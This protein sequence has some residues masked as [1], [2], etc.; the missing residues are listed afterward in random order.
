MNDHGRPDALAFDSVHKAFGRT[1][2]LAG[3]DLTVSAG[4]FL[5]LMGRN[6]AGKTTILRL[7]AGLSRP[8]RGRV[9]V[10]GFPTAGADPQWRSAIGFLSHET[11]LYADLTV[12]ENLM[13]TA[14][15]FGLDQPKSRVESAATWLDTERMLDR[16][17]RALSRGMRQRVGLTRVFLSEPRIVLLDEPYTGLDEASA[18]MLTDLLLRQQ[19][20]GRTI[21]AALHDVSQ[22]GPGPSRV[23]VLENG[24]IGRD[25]DVRRD[26]EVGRDTDVELARLP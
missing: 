8:D 13:F 18:H 14:R 15:L 25:T 2:V 6:G 9:L 5:A 21:I 12:R 10:D 19:D 4:C 11:S 26:T 24:L 3:L 20:A 1:K 16:P 17:V 22:A 23:V 7:A